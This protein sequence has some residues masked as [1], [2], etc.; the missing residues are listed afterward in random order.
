MKMHTAKLLSLFTASLLLLGCGDSQSTSPKPAV[1]QS[2]PGTRVSPL[3]PGA[4]GKIP[5]RV[6]YLARSDPERSKSFRELFEQH[7]QTA[8]VV[9]REE[10]VPSQASEFDVVVLD[11]SQSERASGQYASP[12]GDLENWSTPTVLLGSAGL[13][14]AGPWNVIGGAG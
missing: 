5:L 9:R 12:L 10:F 1:D 3:I 7:F 6:L 2:D 14:I 8:A 11:W 13:L 4:D